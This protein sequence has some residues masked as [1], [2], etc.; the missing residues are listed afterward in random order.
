[1]FRSKNKTATEK[2]KR[3]VLIWIISTFVGIIVLLLVGYFWLLNWLQSDGFRQ[4]MEEDIS[5]KMQAD[6]SI[7]APLQIDGNNIK[8]ASFS[9]NG[10]SYLKQAE[11]KGVEAIINR[12]ELWDRI[13]HAEKIKVDEVSIS[14]SNRKEEPKIY[15]VDEDES[16]FSGFA[17]ETFVVDRIECNNAKAKLTIQRTDPAKKANVYSIDNSSFNATPVN[18]QLDN[19]QVELRKGTFS[20]SHHFLA[21][22][23]ITH[24]RLSYG[25]DT[26]SLDEC[27]LELP[28]GN[29]DATGNYNLQNRKWNIN[30]SAGNADIRNLLN[31]K[32]GKLLTGEFSGHLR[33]DGTYK[34]IHTA[35]GHITLVKG[36]FKALSALSQFLSSKSRGDSAL[37][38]PGQEKASAYL[39]DTFEIIKI[40]SADCDIRY[41]HNAP[42]HKIENAWLF[43]NIDIRTQNDK[44]RLLGHIIIEQDGKL[45]GSIRVGVNKKTVDKFTVLT[46]EPIRS[47]AEMAI[48]KLFNATGD[49]GFYWVNINL[50]GTV[51][52]P[53]QDLSARA[54]EVIASINPLGALSK[55]GAAILDSMTGD[56]EQKEPHENEPAQES[57]GRSLIE[58]TTDTATDIINT[59]VDSIQ[60]FR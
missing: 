50:S 46:T 39:E 47:I 31:K 49:A 29:V 36:E 60:F 32:Y 43:D 13:L 27:Q 55:A 9:C 33:M 15:P 26:I 35:N 23:N 54:G 25:S 10:T 5:G 59:G 17:P 45:H 37:H 58:T 56:S 42:E 24:A 19:W 30:L 28:K 53:R 3:K 51:D 11:I 8:L 38:I 12:S 41:P 6:I 34:T 16:F 2:R 48:P 21:K 40:E 44:L 1:M 7:P 22:S 52:S 18:G 20:T 14:I 57:S 4:S